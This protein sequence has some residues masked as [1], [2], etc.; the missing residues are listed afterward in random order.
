MT[1]MLAW[2]QLLL[3]CSALG[4]AGCNECDPGERRCQAGE[5]EICEPPCSDPGCSARFTRQNCGGTCVDPKNAPAFCALVA[6]PDPKCKGRSQ[7]CDGET[8]VSCTAG[9]R[10]AAHDCG[11]DAHCVVLDYGGEPVPVGSSAVRCAPST[12]VDPRC[13]AKHG[14]DEHCDGADQVSCDTGFLLSVDTCPYA[15]VEPS[16]GVVSC[17]VSSTPDPR[18]AKKA[19]LCDGT[20]LITCV[21]GYLKSIGDCTDSLMHCIEFDDSALCQQ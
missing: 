21:A 7:F 13:P 1:R 15:C 12:E 14:L 9:Y 8:E 16:A 6:Q 4:S 3:I 20:R 19:A 5:L 2:A 11:P 10:V 17:A 18:C